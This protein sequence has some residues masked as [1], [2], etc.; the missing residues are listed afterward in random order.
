MIRRFILALSIVLVAC[1]Q[2]DNINAPPVPKDI[3]AIFD[4][5]AYKQATWGL[6]VV[7]LD[8]GEVIHDLGA[9]RQFLTGSVRKIFSVGQALDQIGPAH[10]VTTPVHRQ[11]SVSGGVLN[12][13][14]VLVAQ[15]DLTMGGRTNPDGSIA[16]DEFDHSDANALG[17]GRLTAPD[18]LAGYASLARQ[19]AASGITRVA[20]DVVIDDRL[21]VPFQFANEFKVSPIFVND[22]M[23]DVVMNPTSPGSLAAVDWRPK[24]AAFNV[25]STLM[26]S[27]A[28]TEE[29]VQLDPNPPRCIG[30]P[31]C[32]GNVSGNLPIDFKPI[33]TNA[34]PMVQTF[35]IDEPANYARTVFI[36]ALRNAGVT[37]DANA[38]APN[39]VAKLPPKNS[40]TAD[41]RVAQLVSFPFSEEAKLILKVSYNVGANAAL[42]LL[43]LANGVDTIDAALVVERHLLADNFGI[44]ASEYHFVDG[45]GGGTT[46]AT[47]RAITTYLR[48]MTRRASFPAFKAALPIL[49]VDGS[50][51]SLQDFQRDAS[52][53]G[54]K[55]NVFAKTGTFIDG[56]AGPPQVRAKALAGYITAKSGRRLAFA[57]AVNDVGTFTGIEPVLQILEDQ[58][59]IAAILWRDD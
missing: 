36:E 12:G 16:I 58:G 11:G 54:A 52:L 50:L 53:A 32:K 41:S 13:D 9:G 38:V 20:G 35:R 46:S 55:G 47:F 25:T 45:G 8:T 37:V 1:N 33:F 31:G 7:D 10:T 23:V 40:Y 26:T 24:S 49:G 57:L 19:V 56:S 22:D 3:Q 42:V 34:Y 14:L 48:G 51:G 39:P 21:W 43:G 4:K 18:P 15:G 44:D 27:A 28:G 17:N 2:G 29:T 59:T 30:S 6:R 5:P